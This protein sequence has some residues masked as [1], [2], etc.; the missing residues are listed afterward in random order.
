MRHIRAIFYF[1]FISLTG[2]SSSSEAQLTFSPA[3][4]IGVYVSNAVA[5][6]D[7]VNLPPY[8]HMSQSV[9]TA[10][11]DESTTLATLRMTFTTMDSPESI[12]AWYTALLQSRGWP[13]VTLQ[14]LPGA[15]GDPRAT[16]GYRVVETDYTGCPL[17]NLQI[18]LKQ[19]RTPF[20]EVTL[21]HRLLCNPDSGCQ[22]CVIHWQSQ[23]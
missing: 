9:E 19:P 7:L 15:S 6:T 5:L 13:D 23:R 11:L 16:V 2:C 10:V 20:T 18:T 8:P 4:M 17:K 14:F 22:A 1:F 21:E 12:L 3:Q